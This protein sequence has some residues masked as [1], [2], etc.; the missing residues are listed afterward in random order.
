MR[1]SKFIALVAVAISASAGA[2]SAADLAARPYSKA[3]VYVEPVYDWTG[4]YIGANVGYSWGRSKDTSTLSAGGPPILFTDTV[5]S[6]MNGVIGG[7]QLG[8]NWQM[9]NW[10]WGLEADFQGTGQR[11]NHSYTCPA[12]VCTPPVGVLAVL[13]GPAVPVNLSQQLDWFG[14]F[15][16][17]AGV[18]VIPKV[19]FYATGGLAYGQVDS[20]STLV[21]ATTANNINAGWTVGGGIEG[22]IGGNWT[23]KIEYLY[24]DLGRVSG[25][26]TTGV[27]ALGG[28]TL[29]SSFNP[30]ITDNIVRAGVNYKFGGPAIAKY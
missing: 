24:V 3:P 28:G 13:P 17:R 9:Q 1:S 18:L 2:A 29:V 6:H 12:G 10:L 16:G 27:A 20:R 5:S 30:R 26:F 11:S 22:A 4:F 8:Y 15:R 19:L 14:T 21:G 25:T 7:G 23:A